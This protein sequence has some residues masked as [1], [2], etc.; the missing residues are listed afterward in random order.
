M[1][2]QNMMDPQPGATGVRVKT[3][4]A[5]DQSASPAKGSKAPPTRSVNGPSPGDGANRTP[6]EESKVTANDKRP[7]GDNTGGANSAA[8]NPVPEAAKSIRKYELHPLAAMFPP[9]QEELAELAADIKRNG[10]RERAVLYQGKLLD[11]QRRQ[12]A[13]EMIGIPLETTTFEG[14]SPAAYVASANLHRRNLTISQ[15]AAIAAEL[16]PVLEAEAKERQRQHGGTAPGRTKTDGAKVRG[17]SGASAADDAA[18]EQPKDGEAGKGSKAS[19]AAA[20]MAGV[21]ARSIETAKALKKSNP[22][23]FQEVKAGKVTLGKAAKTLK[24]QKPRKQ[25]RTLLEQLKG[26]TFDVVYG[27]AELMKKDKLRSVEVD[28]ILDEASGKDSVFFLTLPHDAIPPRSFGPYVYRTALMIVG[29]NPHVIED[30]GIRINHRLM[31]VYVKGKGAKAARLRS[32]EEIPNPAKLINSQFKAA[33]KLMLG[34]DNAPEGWTIVPAP[35]SK[36]EK[37]GKVNKPGMVAKAGTV[38][39]PPSQKEC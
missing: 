23:L 11:G 19:E 32:I 13:C 14:D 12:L 15:R 2:K 21:S 36:N 8:T 7:D 29:R 28:C 34:G 25:S 6:D 31:A 22:A 5:T 33:S 24:T 18:G 35:E 10:Q 16:L 26:K 37:G 30:L 3:E 9:M 38:A 4:P 20:E 1:T 27:D 39:K 17:V